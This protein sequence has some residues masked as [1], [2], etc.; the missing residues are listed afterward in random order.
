MIRLYCI[1]IFAAAVLFLSGN[2]PA[3]DVE[4]SSDIK[5]SSAE[6][7]AASGQDFEAYPYYKFPTLGLIAG[8]RL[9][10]SPGIGGDCPMSPSCSEYARMAFQRYDPLTAMMMTSDRLH[11]CGH[12]PEQYRITIIDG[13][14]RYLDPVGGRA[15]TGGLSG[16]PGDRKTDYSR[17]HLNH[18][19]DSGKSPVDSAGED[20]RLFGFAETLRMEN[21]F[22]G[23]ATEY[24]RLMAYYPH[25]IHWPRAAMALYD[26]L[27]QS[28]RY[29]AAVQYGEELGEHERI[30]GWKTEIDYKIGTGYIRLENYP[31]AHRCFENLVEG[32]SGLYRDRAMLLNG[33]IYARECR[34]KAAGDVFAAVSPASEYYSQARQCV[35]LTR[36][37]ANLNRKSPA[38]AGILAV[39]PGL[40]YLYDGYGQTAL[41]ALIV[42]GLF[43]WGS[44]EAFDHDQPGLGVTLSVIGLGL[45]A[46]NIYGSVN[47]AYRRNARDLNGLMLRFD[48]GFSW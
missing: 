4:S 1:S 21:D 30:Q 44:I 12:D 34:W 41:S 18:Y 5:A 7:P 32:R 6:M 26:C 39:I 27:Y 40:G 31:A 8:Y 19:R 38:L 14:S 11:R 48:L 23:A 15:W 10:I 46:G 17:A 22:V 36:E 33:L 20:D 43:I 2:C 37:A 29:L 9:L 42:N 16:E 28:G 25:S 13:Y 35:Q 45:Y 47:S 3:S 24:R